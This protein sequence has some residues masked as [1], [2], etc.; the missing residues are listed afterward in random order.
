[1]EDRR[2]IIADCYTGRER[3]MS[4]QFKF[5]PID[6][7]KELYQEK[8]YLIANDIIVKDYGDGRLELKCRLMSDEWDDLPQKWRWVFLHKTETDT[9][10]LIGI[11]PLFR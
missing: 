6:Q 3:E 4:D 11:T 10:D 7:V 5:I 1:M 9:Y 8:I 2:I